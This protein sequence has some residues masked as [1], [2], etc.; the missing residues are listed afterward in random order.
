MSVEYMKRGCRVLDGG[1][2]CEIERKG[3]DVNSDPLWTAR[4]LHTNPDVIRDIHLSHLNAGASI[5]ITASYQASVAGF[6]EHLQVS[7]SE[8]MGLIERSVSL[9]RQARDDFIRDK[10]LNDMPPPLIAGSVGPYGACQHD[11]SE[12]TGSYVD[13]MT[14]QEFMDWHRPRV[15]SLLGCGVD[16]LAIETQPALKEALAIVK[17]LREY[18]SARAW[19]TF[20]CK[21][22]LHTCRNDLFSTAVEQI[23]LSPQIV[24]IGVNCTHPSYVTPL[25]ES[26]K[27]CT[28]LPFVVYPNSGNDFSDGKSLC[29]ESFI[30]HLSSWVQL[31]A[32]LIGGCCGVGVREIELIGNE[33]RALRQ[34]LA[35]CCTS[36]PVITSELTLLYDQL[37]HTTLQPASSHHSMTSEIT[38]LYD[39][40]AHTTLRPASSHYSTTTM[41]SKLTLLR[42]VEANRDCDGLGFMKSQKVPHKLTPLYDQ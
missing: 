31:G 26:A 16:L 1:L 15:A 25:L 28:S 4:L 6:C 40:L 23:S 30:P 37:A 21:D 3:F 11:R 33:W 17:L 5:I 8:A 27:G 38:P 2:A 39:Q 42:L 20:S 36:G 14:E 19:V 18:P 32:R 10:F 35:M 13:H 41:T 24:A 22:S 29:G 7:T 34:G 12:Y 9:A